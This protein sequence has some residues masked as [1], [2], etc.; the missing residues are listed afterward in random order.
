MKPRFGKT[1]RRGFTLIELL[2]VVAII[3]IMTATPIVLVFLAQ[4]VERATSLQ[5]LT[6]GQLS[7]LEQSWRHDVGHAVAAPQS[8]HALGASSDS[9]LL[10]FRD[11]QTSAAE[12]H[13]YCTVSDRSIKSG[14]AAEIPL[15]AVERLRISEDGTTLSRQL[16]AAGLLQADF[17]GG[18]T[19]N[20]LTLKV[21]AR[22][23]FM[24][25]NRVQEFTA[26]SYLG[27]DL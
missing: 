9:C 2:I 21:K 19:S 6:M 11:S 27:G 12:L 20:A 22:S 5:Q 10:A 7:V 3:A 4:R 1:V 26:L 23:G 25:F 14:G 8:W 15:L 24:D 18:A 13:V 17:G 16:L